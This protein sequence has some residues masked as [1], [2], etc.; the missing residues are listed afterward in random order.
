MELNPN[1]GIQ[2]LRKDNPPMP[3]TITF[4]IPKNEWLTSNG[5]YHHMDRAKRTHTLRHKAYITALQALQNGDLTHYDVLPLLVIQ[6][7]YSSR[8]RADPPN[9]YPTVKALIDG[10]TDAG[11][12]D[13]DNSD[14]IHSCLFTRNQEKAPTGH[15]TITFTFISHHMPIHDGER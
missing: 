9:A 7:G 2:P 1:G 6:V 11:L 10:C 5:R 14:I 15:Y 4:T 13:D 12:W 3:Q 8:R